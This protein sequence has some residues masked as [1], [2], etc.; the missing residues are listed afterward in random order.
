M[1]EAGI[2][3]A[4]I[5]VCWLI[6]NVIYQDDMTLPRYGAIALLVVAAAYF[7]IRFVRLQPGRNDVK[8]RT[9]GPCNPIRKLSVLAAF[10]VLTRRFVGEGETSLHAHSESR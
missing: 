10:S 5:I 6:G 8:F 4:G 3:V 1:T 9:L 2:S 7:A